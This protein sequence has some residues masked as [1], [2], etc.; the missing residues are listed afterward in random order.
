MNKPIRLLLVDDNPDDRAMALRALRKE[1]SEVEAAEI[2]DAESLHAALSRFRFDL[3]IVDYQLQWST[4]LDL[5][6]RIREFAPGCPVIM[7]TGSG[8][9]EIAVSALKAGFDDYVLKSPRH[10]ARLTASARMAVE[11]VR[12]R[13]R[14]EAL[15]FRLEDLLSRL[16]VGV[17]RARLDG[18]IFYANPAFRRIFSQPP[19]PAR[20]PAFDR[21]LPDFGALDTAALVDGEESFR[22]ARIEGPGGRET[23]I[24]VARS[25]SLM[26]AWMEGAVAEPGGEGTEPV[27][28][29]LVEDI[30]ERKRLDQELKHQEES[31]RNLKSLEAVSRLA[32]GVAHD[33]NNMLTAINGYSEILLAA[34]E[35]DHPLRES[36]EQINLAGSR[37]ARLTRD[38][39]AFGR[40]Q[41]M[42]AREFDLN[43]FL[44]ALAPE[45]RRMLGESIHLDLDLASVPLRV[46]SDPAQLETVFF[47]M[48]HNAREAMPE[49]GGLLI[50]TSSRRAGKAQ[51]SREP[52]ALDLPAEGAYAVVTVADSGFGM[53]PSV[54]ARVFEPFFSTK[55]MAKRTGMG[56]SA[57]YGI[58]KQCGGTITVESA[59]GQGTR[60]EV[61]IPVSP[62]GKGQST[63]ES[64]RSEPVHS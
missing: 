58:V 8:N 52:Q 11:R 4:G 63:A 20:L 47:N 44:A 41:M 35:K 51:P 17:C 12:E 5:F 61:W 53:E 26:P 56:L 25:L 38:L 60:F 22:E 19:A 37:A 10:F 13:R 62:K 6:A 45:I 16:N 64:S 27:V 31:V 28:E 46:F 32:G 57:A 7:F 2:R 43:P 59:P 48:V 33:F 29:M 1:F 39:L 18:S 30:S 15:D 54:L 24:R 49:G 34:M 55:P 3:A 40:S 50:R 36:L 42:Q 21:L 14:A 9:E 23:W